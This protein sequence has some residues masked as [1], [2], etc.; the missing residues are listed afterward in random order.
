M[1]FWV[2]EFRLEART[3]ERVYE[4]VKNFMQRKKEEEERNPRRVSFLE[5]ERQRDRVCKWSKK[6][7]MERRRK[8]RKRRNE[9]SYSNGG[10]WIFDW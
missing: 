3:R 4:K 8:R 5:T 10:V 6:R 1:T 9:K 7:I 2:F